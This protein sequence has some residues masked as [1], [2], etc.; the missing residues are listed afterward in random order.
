MAL[1]C[2]EADEQHDPEHS[3]KVAEVLESLQKQLNVRAF[4]ILLCS[5]LFLFPIV[6][7]TCKHLFPSWFKPTQLCTF[8]T[9]PPPPVASSVQIREGDLLCVRELVGKCLAEYAT[10]KCSRPNSRRLRWII[11]GRTARH[12]KHSYYK[13]THLPTIPE[14]AY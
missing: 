10:S 3:D 6:D 4:L 9:P 5:D 2:Y 8:H 11:S 7:F 12:L 13:I 1:L 14:S